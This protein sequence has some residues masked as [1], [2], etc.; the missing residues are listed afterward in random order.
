MK[1]LYH[2]RV[3]S[4]DGQYVHIAEII[5]S[6]RKLGHEVIIC[7]PDSVEKTSFGGA[8]GTVD[9]ARELLPGFVHEL[10]EFFYSV[11]DYRKMRRLIKQHKPDCIYERYNLLFPSGI[12]AAKAF[13][14]PLVAEVNAPLYEERLRNN[15]I[16]LKR[17]ARWS[18]RFV[19]SSA[20][21]VLPVT[22]V[23]ADLVEQQGVE[24]RNISVIANGINTEFG[25]NLPPES[26]IDDRL[27]LKGKLVLGFTG[28]VRE[29]HGLDRAL[30]VIASD[31]TGNSHLL[32]VGAGP[33]LPRLTRLAEE[34]G[35]S[36]G[37]TVTGVVGREE[38]PSYVQRFD[39]ALQPDV[40]AYASPLKMF[41]YMALAKPIIAPDTANIREILTDQDNAL[42]FDA[43]ADDF[44]EKTQ[45][46]CRNS[47]LRAQ[48]GRRA[49]ET[50]DEKGLYW[51]CNGEKIVSIFE[52]LIA[53]KAQRG[54]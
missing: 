40:V 9:K 52:S 17:L 29:W 13:N 8:S 15:G 30:Q 18:E 4:K 45:R 46:L 37:F 43:E 26:E 33:D 24:P 47:E 38:M 20:D 14:L 11:L 23:L 49:K 41:E 10:A 44:V 35:V 51:D 3:A 16:S 42:L 19:W 36:E 22:G 32:L 48:L 27:A 53:K 7:E 50:I 6:L 31:L 1:I 25:K 21:H 54:G 5:A 28:F 34:M 12:W 39:V 2:H